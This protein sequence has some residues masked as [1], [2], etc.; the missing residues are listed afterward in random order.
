MFGCRLLKLPCRHH[1]FEV[2]CGAILRSVYGETDSPSKVLFE[3]L[4]DNWEHIDRT[5]YEIYRP[6]SRVMQAKC[7][8]S[9]TFCTEFLACEDLC[10]E[11]YKELLILVVVFLG[12]AFL[13]FPYIKM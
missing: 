4:R 10:R 11:D 2:V 12:K 7:Q 9:I 1:I 3:I 6:A 8:E 5:N 13:F